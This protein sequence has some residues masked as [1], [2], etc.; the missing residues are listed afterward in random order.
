MHG[1]TDEQAKLA[2]RTLSFLADMD[3]LFFDRIK[4]LNDDATYEVRHFNSEFSDNEVKVSRGAVIEKGGRLTIITK[5]PKPPMQ[6]E[7]RWGRF[8]ALDAHPK[9]P[10]VGMLHAAFL[11]NFD[12]EGKGI[13]A[14]WLDVL[15]AARIDEDLAYLKEIMDGVYTKYG[16]D[17]GGPRGRLSG[18][19]KSDGDVE[20]NRWQRRSAGV[21]GN[22]Y[23]Y[24]M[25]SATEENYRFMTEAYERFV[26][27]YL[28][29]VEK[30]QGNPFSP[31]D[32]A[33]QDAM[34][35]NWLEDQLF[36]DEWTKS[37]VPY[38]VWSLA[39]VP[40]TIKF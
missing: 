14:G 18:N 30:R 31:E 27:A 34:R 17:D 29:I 11:I 35:R 5:K 2:D 28:K 22:F 1:L 21:G 7:T 40:P 25:L 26:D 10:L 9:T 38:E 4:K 13:I 32:L 39:N 15:P 23:G 20:V 6:R 3:A 19:S 12:T 36:A 8:F 37:V 33:A 24:P 16:I